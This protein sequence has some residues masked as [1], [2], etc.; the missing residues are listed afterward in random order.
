MYMS[1]MSAMCLPAAPLAHL[2]FALC[3]SLYCTADLHMGQEACPSACS[4]HWM[5]HESQNSCPQPRVVERA[6][7][8][9]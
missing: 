5:A 6:P 2:T 8:D 1:V 9:S 3:T 7:T 4:Y